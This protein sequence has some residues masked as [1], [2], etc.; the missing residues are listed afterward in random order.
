MKDFKATKK[1]LG[2]SIVRDRVARTMNL[3]PQEYIKMILE[4]FNMND[5]KPK[6]APLR[7]QIKLSEKQSPKKDEDSEE[8]SKISCAP[9]VGCLLYAMVCTR[10]DITHSVGVVSRLCQNQVKRIG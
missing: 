7:S 5:A 10:L 3:S 6:S 1:I 2:M 4:K 8:M 9:L